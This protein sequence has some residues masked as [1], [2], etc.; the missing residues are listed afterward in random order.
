MAVVT[1]RSSRTR[2]RDEE[3]DEEPRGRRGRSARD[4][5]EAPARGRGRSEPVDL[6]DDDAGYEDE[7]APPSRG[8]ARGRDEESGDVPRGR[9]ARANR[10]D[11]E[12]DERPR[13]RTSRSRPAEDDEPPARGRGRGRSR[14]DDEPAPS[15]AVSSGW[16]SA[17]KIKSEGGQYASEFKITDK[18]QLIVFLQDE[19]Y[20]NYKQHWVNGLR[21]TGKKSF[22]CLGDKTCP[23]CI[24]GED[25]SPRFAFNIA[26]IEGK[27]GEETAEIKSLIAASMLFD[28]ISDEHEGSDGPLTAGPWTLHKTGQK[29]ST[30][31]KLKRMEGRKLDADWG[32]TEDDVD[33]IV[34]EADLELYTA[35]QHKPMSRSS[36][37]DI[38]DE[39]LGNDD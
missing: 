4:E 8:R 22:V 1:R 39:L 20:A 31:Y 34:A 28:A 38:A 35:E 19:P 3:P 7:D 32:L 6:S 14:D 29:K 27:E 11:N 24:V 16:G 36:L 12:E 2:P 21:S 10:E 37:Q 18:P 23:L 33:D 26:V 13:F 9:R 5:D 17:K 15:N 30:T 25:K